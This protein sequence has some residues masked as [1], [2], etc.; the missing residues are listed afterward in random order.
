MHRSCQLSLY[1]C[2]RWGNPASEE[3]ANGE[4]TNFLV[5][6]SNHLEAARIADA[7]LARM[8]TQLE[9]STVRVAPYCSRVVELGFDASEA[10]PGLVLRPWVA[11]SGYFGKAVYR[12]WQRGHLPDDLAWASEEEIFGPR[13]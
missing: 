12:A 13:S 3:G 2:V 9:G 11:D 4:D 5:R 10:D 8:P 1:Y 6:A 7:E